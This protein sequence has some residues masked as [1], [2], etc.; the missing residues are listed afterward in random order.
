MNSSIPWELTRVGEGGCSHAMHGR[1][2]NTTRHNPTSGNNQVLPQ[3]RESNCRGMGR[4]RK[5]GEGEVLELLASTTKD[6]IYLSAQSIIEHS[7]PLTMGMNSWVGVGGR[8][9][10]APTGILNTSPPTHQFTYNDSTE[11]TSTPH[12]ADTYSLP[13]TP[14]STAGCHRPGYHMC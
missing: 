12:I 13:S 5:G 11:D 10:G 8:G 3:Y 1:S 2:F 6:K 9:G 4:G 7:P 14:R